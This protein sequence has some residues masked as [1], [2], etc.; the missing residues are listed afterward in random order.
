[1]TKLLITGSRDASSQMLAYARSL[2]LRARE[3]GWSIVVGDASGIDA[4]VIKECDRLGVKVIV[5]GAF[6]NIRHRTQTGTNFP[7]SA[8]SYS[9]RDRMMAQVCDVCMAVWNG[10]SAGTRLT[11]LAAKNYGKKVYIKDF[12]VKS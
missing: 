7:T 12:G 10:K 6:G 5:Y 3:M 9:E 1:M 2:V 4:E 11:Y 8:K